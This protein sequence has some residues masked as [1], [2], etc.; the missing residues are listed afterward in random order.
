M[1]R[2]RLLRETYMKTDLQKLIVEKRYEFRIRQEDL[3]EAVGVTPQALR[4]KIKESNFGRAE[5]IQL[6]DVLKFSSDEILKVM[7]K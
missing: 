4:K 2:T 7:K 6:F 5:L 1:P 3:A